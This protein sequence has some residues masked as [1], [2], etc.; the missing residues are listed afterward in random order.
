MLSNAIRA[1]LLKNAEEAMKGAYAPYSKFRVG[2]S[3]LSAN[4]E[5]YSGANVEN[6]SYG[7]SICAERI[8][9]SN[10]ILALGKEK[11]KAICVVSE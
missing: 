8:A 3:V 4:N 7:L 10:C 6:A 5:F 9:C 11:I 1:E 2:C